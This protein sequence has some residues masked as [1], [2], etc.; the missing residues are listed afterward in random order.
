M[1]MKTFFKYITFLFFLCFMTSQQLLAQ[2]T[3]KLEWARRVFRNACVSDGYN[4]PSVPGDGFKVY[5]RWTPPFPNASN[6]YYIE[7][8]DAEGSF[9]NPTV[10]ATIEGKNTRTDLSE[11][12]TFPNT[13][14]GKKYQIRVRSTNPASVAVTTYENNA[15]TESME[16]HYTS[17]TAGIT[18][19]PAAPSPLCPGH[20]V[21]LKVTSISNG[22]AVDKYKY[23]WGK[24]V[25]SSDVPIVSDAGPTFSVSEPG[26]YYASIDYGRCSSSGGRSRNIVVTV[27]NTQTITLSSSATDICTNDSFTLTATPADATSKYFWFRDGT[28]IGETTGQN[29]FTVNAPDNKAGKYYVEVGSG[30]D[31][32][33]RSNAIEIK[34]KDVVA[35]SLVTTGSRVLLPGKSFTFTVSTTAQLPTYKWFKDGVELTGETASTYTAN[36]VGKYKAEVTQTGGCSVSVVTDEIELRGPSNFKVTIKPKTAYQPCEYSAITLAVD[37]I[38]AQVDDKELVIDPTDY[39]FFSF[40]WQAN[41]NGTYANAATTQELSLSNAFENGKYKLSLSATGFTAIPDSNELDV[42]LQD[43]NALKLN[44]GLTN[45][46]FCEGTLTLTIT[47]GANA[48]A[49]YTWYKDGNTQIAQGVG[50]TE[51]N[52]DSSGVYH[53]QVAAGFGGCPATSNALAVNKNII[54]ARWAD[55]TKSDEIFFIGKTNVLQVSHNMTAPTIEWKKDGVIIAGQ[56]DTQLTVT[57]PGIYQVTLTNNGTGCNNPM[58]LTPVHFENIAD[59][60]QVKVGTLPSADCETRSQT[61]LELQKVVVKLSG[62][63]EVEVK[64]DDY[65]YFNLQWT[66]DGSDVLAE[67]RTKYEV[68]RLG[69]SES[70]LY[71]VRVTYNGSILKTSDPKAIAFTPIPDFEISALDGAKGTVYL[72]PGGTLSLTVA[73]DSFDPN[74]S[75]ADSFSYVWKKVTSQNYLNDTPIGSELPTAQVNDTGDYYLEINNGGCPKR[76]HIVVENYHTGRI[77]LELFRDGASQKKVYQTSTEREREF[78]VRV[79]DKLE[80]GGGNNFVW[81]HA[82][83]TTKYGTTLEI[84]SSDMAGDYVLS[85]TSCPSVGENSLPFK[86]NVY[87]VSTIPN[88][89]TPN[90]DGVN[91]T[92]EIP[93]KYMSPQVKVTIYSQEGKEVF[94]ATN[95]NGQWPDEKTFKDLGN[96][97]QIFFYLLEGEATNESGGKEDMPKKGFITV[98]K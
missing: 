19:T 38:V 43:A 32:D 77:T 60:T 7:L 59:I 70:A 12:L 25:N 50:L 21:E 93:A 61:T 69:N 98:L 86:L 23:V 79:G 80:A 15:N 58:T 71:A 68:S 84:T 36:D 72:C 65:Q 26:T 83:G 90:A 92:W 34:R 20:S 2:S 48:S 94:S 11:K 8:S 4:G 35:A 53:V 22:D 57:A 75:I 73:K 29:N 5:F 14:T 37:K 78:P 1:K 18:V 82:D 56:T 27:M 30:G 3:G 76:A 97:A 85:E 44:G 55:N 39:N 24:I 62:G 91:D 89:V 54:T 16:I 74:S 81:K 42:L 31:C 51:Y 64:K 46:E 87:Q 40:Q 52:V 33:V 28:K 95:Y 66:K 47:T 13:V 88:V 63:K 6:K 45:L 67:T 9:D 10:L 41:I 17:V 49:T 96:R